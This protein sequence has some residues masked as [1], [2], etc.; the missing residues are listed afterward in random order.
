MSNYFYFAT[1]IYHYFL[2]YLGLFNWS[3]SVLTW[4]RWWCYHRNKC[5]IS[6]WIFM[7]C[8][9][10][11]WFHSLHWRLHW[12]WWFV[13]NCDRNFICDCFWFFGSLV[14]SN[15]QL[16]NQTSEPNTACW[17]DF[18]SK[19]LACQIFLL[20]CQWSVLEGKRNFCTVGSAT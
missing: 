2:T 7:C 1:A 16:S 12:D 8:C 5:Q 6:C 15:H 4:Q 10:Y 14:P 13:S 3:W 17:G 19:Q 11:C 20:G 9:C 18:N